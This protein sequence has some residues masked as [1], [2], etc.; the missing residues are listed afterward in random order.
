[1]Y[2]AI[3]QCLAPRPSA[4]I[5]THQPLQ[6]SSNSSQSREQIRVPECPVSV[7]LRVQLLTPWRRIAV[8]FARF[9]PRR[10]PGP[11][12]VRR[13]AA[14]CQSAPVYRC[15]V[16]EKTLKDLASSRK[17]G[18]DCDITA[19]RI[20]YTCREGCFCQGSV[21]TAD[22]GLSSHGQTTRARCRWSVLIVGGGEG[23]TAYAD[24]ST[25]L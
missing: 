4:D 19:M 15:L 16:I 24:W 12:S 13:T 22:E 20:G 10:G 25:Y 1:M 14:R 8:Y 11:Y 18:D 5:S 3:K 6:L 17:T 7:Q 21:S 23:H 9:A 2:R